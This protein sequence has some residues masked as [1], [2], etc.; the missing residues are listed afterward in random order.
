VRGAIAT[1]AYRVAQECL[2]N[3]LRHG[4]A[5][6][7]LLRIER[8]AGAENVLMICVEDDAAAML[9]KW[10]SRPASALLEYVRG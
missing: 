10:H 6:E 7:I 1:T 3:S 9:R 5:R 4:G 8:R 2:T